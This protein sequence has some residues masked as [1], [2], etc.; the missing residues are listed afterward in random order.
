MKTPTHL[1]LLALSLGG[2][3]CSGSVPV[4]HEE[5]DFEDGED[6]DLG[7]QP[8]RER[9]RM[10]VDQLEASLREVTG[11][12]GWERMNGD[13]T[14]RTR[15]FREYADTL[16]MPDY[17]NSSAED[18][19]V[20]LL[21]QKF[22]DDAARS[23]CR[24]VADREAGDGPSYEAEPQGTFAP[25]DLTSETPPTQAEIDAALAALLLRFHGRRVDVASPEL[26]PWRALEARLQAAAT[27][28]EAPPKRAWEGVCVA[29]ITHPDF[30]TY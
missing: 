13:G 15:Y 17:I 6:V 24:R 11:G 25:V 5:H 20:S 7:T 23:A 16:G 18:L 9:R 3:S 1:F 27:E 14:V 2:L 28:T 30:Y 21:F 10:D 4:D 19:S 22:L 29:L 8:W 12:I 26:E